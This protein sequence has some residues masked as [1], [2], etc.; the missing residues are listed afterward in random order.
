MIVMAQ[1]K[2]FHSLSPVPEKFGK[3]IHAHRASQA[4]FTAVDLGIFDTFSKSSTPLFAEDIS[5]RVSSNLDATTRL[6]DSLVSLELLEKTDQNG[7]WQYNNSKIASDFL[8][9]TSPESLV[10]F[11]TVERE[12]V[13]PMFCNLTSAIREGKSQWIRTFGKTSEELWKGLYDNKEATIRFM[14]AMHSSSLQGC[15]AVAEA[16]DLSEFT[17]CCDLGGAVGAMAYALCHHNPQ[18]K[19]TV[20]EQPIVVKYAPHFKPSSEDCPNQGNVSFL[21]GDF[22]EDDLPKADLY[23]ISR[24]LH[25]W[26]DEKVDLILSKVF[27]SLPSGGGLLVCE[28]ILQ[29]DKS[30][31]ENALLQSLN[32]LLLCEGRERSFT[33]YQQLLEKHGFVDFQAKQVS[34]YMDGIL[35]RKA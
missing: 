11:I 35:S 7:S 30:G 21:T 8:T 34:F 29:D 27:D 16:F 26:S 15:Y 28:Q 24:T 13:V 5:K 9:S 20:C 12:K 14:G 33:E 6:L 18:M 4:L 3:L 23:V 22:I 17:S 32:M 19:I 10:D 1:S 2:N 25:N 31:P